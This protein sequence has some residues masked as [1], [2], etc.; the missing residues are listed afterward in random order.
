[1]STK[2]VFD[3]IHYP[4]AWQNFRYNVYDWIHDHAA[5]LLTIVLVA[6]VIGS[7]SI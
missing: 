1:M 3:D 2:I 4:T 6:I 5:L 7:H